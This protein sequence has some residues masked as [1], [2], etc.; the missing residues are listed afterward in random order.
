[1]DVRQTVRRVFWRIGQGRVQEDQF[2]RAEESGIRVSE[3]TQ[4]AFQEAMAAL[5][6]EVAS[7]ELVEF[8]LR[9]LL[10]EITSEA[11]AESAAAADEATRLARRGLVIE[12][13][14]IDG[15][16]RGVAGTF[17]T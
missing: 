16:G 11:M 7:I 2:F 14:S 13:V 10:Q 9:S 8:V 6:G 4:Q 15:E 1:M 3:E 17:F 5:K 12:R